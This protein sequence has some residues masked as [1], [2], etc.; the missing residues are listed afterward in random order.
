MKRTFKRVLLLLFIIMIMS[1]AMWCPELIAIAIL[2]VG[3]YW[4]W[5]ITDA[6]IN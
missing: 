4:V 5:I 6:L 2:F 1:S 3:I